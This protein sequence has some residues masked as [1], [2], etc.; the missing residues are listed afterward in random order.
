VE[1]S[2]RHVARGNPWLGV[3]GCVY[4]GGASYFVSETRGMA[5]RVCAEPTAADAASRARSASPS[6]RMAADDARWSVPPSLS[7]DAAGR[8]TP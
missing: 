7:A 6:P 8:S 5:E 2:G 3:A 1:I 4:M